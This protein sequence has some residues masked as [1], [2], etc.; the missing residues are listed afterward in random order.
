MKRA[1]WYGVSRASD[2]GKDEV[3]VRATGAARRRRWLVGKASSTLRFAGLPKL[4]A[5]GI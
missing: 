3:A 1:K 5:S 4:D 2:V